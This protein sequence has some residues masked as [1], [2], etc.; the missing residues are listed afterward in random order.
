MVKKERITQN[1]HATKQTKILDIRNV[2]ILPD[3]ASEK[4]EIT[5]FA[6]E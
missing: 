2:Q 6:G 3:G 1:V 4:L 5:I